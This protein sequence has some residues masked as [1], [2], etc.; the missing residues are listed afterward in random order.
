MLSVARQ[1]DAAGGGGRKLPIA[2]YEKLT[3]RQVSAR[4][5]G[6]SAAQLRA[7]QAFERRHANRKSLL[8]L[9]DQ[10]LE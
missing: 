10:A 5:A 8:A 9:I 4:L 3:V 2:G 6:L 1:S 7:V